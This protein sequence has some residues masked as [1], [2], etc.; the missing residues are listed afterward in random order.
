MP[1][2]F[3]PGVLAFCYRTPRFRLAPFV[4]P[5]PVEG[6]PRLRARAPSVDIDFPRE[7]L[8]ICSFSGV[9]I[10]PGS[11]PSAGLSIPRSRP[12]RPGGIG[13]CDS[14]LRLVTSVDGMR[15]CSLGGGGMREEPSPGEGP[16]G[17]NAMDERATEPEEEVDERDTFDKVALAVNGA[18]EESR[19][20][21]GDIGGKG[22][23]YGPEGSVL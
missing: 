2:Y 1:P 19:R 8:A 7:R 4:R 22:Y 20:V 18:L 13:P 11:R 23:S 16:E 15:E 9:R 5:P 14:S 6:A 10:S 3:Y 12:I 21:V 17:V